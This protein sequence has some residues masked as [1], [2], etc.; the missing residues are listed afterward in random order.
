MCAFVQS[1]PHEHNEIVIGQPRTKHAFHM[2]CNFFVD[3]NI[4]AHVSI[5]IFFNLTKIEN[6]K[7]K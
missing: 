1:C 3:D 2:I 5:N 7:N 6:W 4:N